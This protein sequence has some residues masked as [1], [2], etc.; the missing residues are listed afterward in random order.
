MWLKQSDKISDKI[1]IKS[2]HDCITNMG[3]WDKQIDE[4][5]HSSMLSILRVACRCNNYE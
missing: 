1:D 2:L 5:G 3:K 4:K